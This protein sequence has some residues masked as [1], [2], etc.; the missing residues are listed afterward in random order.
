VVDLLQGGRRESLE[1][2][3]SVVF[4]VEKLVLAIEA[5]LLAKATA[6]RQT[7]SIRVLR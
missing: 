2:C 4:A 5:G 7:S 3:R 6:E 1:G